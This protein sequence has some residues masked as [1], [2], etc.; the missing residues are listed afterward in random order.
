MNDKKITTK[1]Y[2]YPFHK[3]TLIEIREMMKNLR[4]LFSCFKLIYTLW[5]YHVDTQLFS[6]RK[7]FPS[8]L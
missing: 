7:V 4:Y 5:L 6:I 2:L 1:R 3:E 8:I